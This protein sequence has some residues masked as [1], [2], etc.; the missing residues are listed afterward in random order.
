MLFAFGP[1]NL[2]DDG[3]RQA[4]MTA[5]ILYLGLSEGVSAF[6]PV[7]AGA[8]PVEELPCGA[9]CAEEGACPCGEH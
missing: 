4:V 3:P 8:P 7:V 9:D 5:A 2:A 6:D 1:P